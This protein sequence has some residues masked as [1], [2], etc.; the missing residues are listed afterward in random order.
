MPKNSIEYQNRV[1]W[2]RGVH[3]VFFLNPHPLKGNNVNN[4]LF[5]LMFQNSN[6]FNYIYKYK[7]GL[8]SIME[9]NVSSGFVMLSMAGST[10]C[11]L[12]V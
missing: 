5:L 8:G 3:C 10:L 6:S 9:N 12:F 11:L 4:F 2:M 1:K 7:T